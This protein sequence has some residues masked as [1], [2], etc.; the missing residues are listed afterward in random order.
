MIKR[1][2]GSV[3]EFKKPSILTLILMVGE[4]IIEVLIPFIDADLIYYM[5]EGNVIIPDIV[6]RGLLLILMAFL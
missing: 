2:L 6:K 1:L 3:R 5:S 4:V